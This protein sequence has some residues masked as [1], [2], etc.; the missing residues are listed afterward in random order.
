MPAR[1]HDS[2]ADEVF[3]DLAAR[4]SDVARRLLDRGLSVE[5]LTAVLPDLEVAIRT[6]AADVDAPSDPAPPT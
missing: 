1:D 6:A 5:T 2:A 3:V 4:R